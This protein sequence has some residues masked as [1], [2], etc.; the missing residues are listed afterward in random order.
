M[1]YFPISTCSVKS[2]SCDP[3]GCSLPGYSVHGISQARI[4]EWV[5]ISFSRWSSPP[6]D[7][8]CV[9]C[10]SRQILYHWANWEAHFPTSVSS[11][12]S[13]SRV[14]LCNPMNCSCQASL[15]IT[16]S[17]SSL[18]LM[19]LKLVMPSNHLILCRPFFSCPQSYPAS[20]SF[21]MSQFFSSGGQSI[22]VST[23]TSVL[24]M[25]IQDWS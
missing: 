22:R 24:S 25:N 4:L 16:N 19:S 9:S 12:Q 18:K 14:R 20:E 5:A 13:L 8:T 7:Q 15:S 23:S 3:M 6:R 17:R 2:D 1:T 21:Q 10:I 11:V